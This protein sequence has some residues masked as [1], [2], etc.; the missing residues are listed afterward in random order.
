MPMQTVSIPGVRR[1]VSRLLAGAVVL[2]SLVVVAQAVHP[3]TAQAASPVVRAAFYYPWFPNAWT[4]NGIYPYTK[5][6]PSSGYYASN[7]QSVVR[8]QIAAMQYGHLDTGVI[9]WWGQGS[10]EDGVVPTDLAAAA[11]TGFKWSLYYEPE[12]YSDPSVAQIQSDLTY[13]KSK[14][15][16][17]PSYL[18]I[19]GKPVIFV[20]GDAADGCGMVT[21]WSQANV[22]PGLLHR[23]EGLP[24][25]RVVCRSAQ[26]L[27]PVR[28]SRPRG[29]ATGHQLLDQPRL[30]QGR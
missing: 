1:A 13:I 20:Y 18:T 15:A 25:L 23:V 24:R 30:Q 19:G 9:S 12:G 10:Q 5:Y 21:R 29:P 6:S 7:N 17:D 2:G 22:V 3:A 26:Q 16:S 4:Q 14:Y 28:P 8:Q 11:G 27:A